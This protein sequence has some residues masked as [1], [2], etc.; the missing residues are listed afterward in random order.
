VTD[1]TELALRL[2]RLAAYLDSVPEW[3]AAGEAVHTAINLID[4]MGQQKPAEWQ[5]RMRADWMAGWADWQYCSQEQAEDY[6][7][8]PH[9]NNWHYE[10][11][12]LYLH[13]QP[14]IPPGYRLVPVDPTPEMERA[15]GH[16]NSEWL[17]DSAPIGEQR[18]AMPMKSVWRD[19]LA[20]APQEPDWTT[21]P[22]APGGPYKTAE[23]LFA[24]LNAQPQEQQ[25]SSFADLERICAESYQVVGWL[26]SECGLFDHE[27]VI[28]ALDNLSEQR[29]VH[30]DVLPFN[31]QRAQPQEQKPGF[32]RQID[33]ARERVAALP[34]HL[35][36][37]AAATFPT[38]QPQ[39]QREPLTDE[40]IFELA[41]PF[42]EFQFGDAQGHKRLAF[43][44]AIERAHGIGAAFAAKEK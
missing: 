29:L 10:V 12:K 33:A 9:V 24:A 17:N 15:G 32:M 7:R 23:E 37:E 43:A 20:A 27:Q 44:R 11:R 22:P 25:R 6:L 35:R 4:A 13:P 36:V 2:H 14:A 28:K 18:Y 5:Y 38:M 39:E 8:S 34:D 19:M 41:D 21:E 1:Y 26:A 3:K 42:G 16:A 31:P 30:D 40:Q